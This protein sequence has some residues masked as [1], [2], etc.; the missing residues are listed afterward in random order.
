MT[1]AGGG[2]T[3]RKDPGGQ[4]AELE[5]TVHPHVE[6]AQQQPQLLEQ[7][8]GQQLQRRDYP[9]YSTLISVALHFSYHVCLAPPPT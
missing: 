9:L 1:Q 8:H 7:E 6:G 5:Q 4:R 3:F 2:Q